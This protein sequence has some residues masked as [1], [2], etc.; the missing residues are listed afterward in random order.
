MPF[1]MF[2]KFQFFAFP[3]LQQDLNLPP[4]TEKD[5]F[6]LHRCAGSLGYCLTKQVVK[7]FKQLSSTHYLSLINIVTVEAVQMCVI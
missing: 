6:T 4:V 7:T 3:P 2:V 1:C 5:A